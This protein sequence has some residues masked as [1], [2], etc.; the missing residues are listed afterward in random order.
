MAISFSA[1][2]LGT[3]RNL[4]LALILG[5]G[6]IFAS[7]LT[8]LGASMSQM[9]H[10]ELFINVM[11]NLILAV[12]AGM[13]FEFIRSINNLRAGVVD[14][15]L[16][17]HR[18]SMSAETHRSLYQLVENIKSDI[19][20]PPVDDVEK[21]TEDHYVRFI[22]SLEIRSNLLKKR[23]RSILGT[24]DGPELGMMAVDIASTKPGDR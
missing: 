8:P 20:H 7:I 22:S 10:E 15:A 11:D 3:S 24:I 18:A 16:E 2:F 23:R 5:A 9:R 14:I 4:V 17:S 21:S 6:I 1:W 13:V 12:I 19:G